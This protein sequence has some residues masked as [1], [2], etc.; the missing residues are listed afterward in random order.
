MAHWSRTAELSSI[1]DIAEFATLVAQEAGSL[2][3]RRAIFWA[4]DLLKAC[5]S[6]DMVRMNKLFGDFPSLAG[7]APEERT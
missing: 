2:G 3:D 7:V 1:D 5:D 6:F 4:E